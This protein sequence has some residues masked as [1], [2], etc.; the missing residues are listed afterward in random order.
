MEFL[1][2]ELFWAIIGVIFAVSLGVAAPTLGSYIAERMGFKKRKYEMYFEVKL[3]VYSEFISLLG[4]DKSLTHLTEMYNSP[5]LKSVMNK[6]LII[7][8]FE[9]CELIQ[10]VYYLAG[11]ILENPTDERNQEKYYRQKDQLIKA[12][13]LELFNEKLVDS[14]YRKQNR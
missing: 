4:N 7:S 10:W 3:S 8:S 2:S 9:T 1:K 12:M 6:A 5:H 14:K 11:D 13:Q